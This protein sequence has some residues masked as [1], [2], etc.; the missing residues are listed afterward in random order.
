MRRTTLASC[1]GYKMRP[2]VAWRKKSP[3]ISAETIF[4]PL[5][6]P[7]SCRGKDFAYIDSSFGVLGPGSMLV[8]CRMHQTKEQEGHSQRTPSC[9]SCLSD[10]H[11][12]VS[13][14]FTAVSYAHNLA[15]TPN[16]TRSHG[17][18]AVYRRDCGQC[19]TLV[20][21]RLHCCPP[22]FRRNFGTPLWFCI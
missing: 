17:I 22:F 3:Q 2:R 7:A 8:L 18:K 13:T 15:R 20:A 5:K 4:G 11:L 21:S 16:M 6:R 1:R 9:N 12:P 10:S 19:E 14:S